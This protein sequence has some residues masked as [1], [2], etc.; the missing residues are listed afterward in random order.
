MEQINMFVESLKAFW[1][2]FDVAA[3][4]SGI[5][6]F[7]IKGSVG[8]LPSVETLDIHYARWGMFTPSDIPFSRDAIASDPPPNIET[9][10]F[11]D[12]DL[13]LFTR[14]RVSRSVLS[15]KDRRGDLCEV[16][17]L[18]SEGNSDV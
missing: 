17:Y 8:N 10:I 6:D 9:V 16:R 3:E 5:K 15:W 4:K 13:N 14:Q 7:L 12:L 18:K 2:H 11:E 1:L